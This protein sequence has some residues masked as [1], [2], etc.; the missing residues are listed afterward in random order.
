MLVLGTIHPDCGLE[1]IS[2]R[3]IK[4]IFR[5]RATL[6][7]D[8][9][10]VRVGVI[11]NDNNHG[12]FGRFGRFGSASKESTSCMPWEPNFGCWFGVHRKFLKKNKAEWT[13]TYP[14]MNSEFKKKEPNAYLCEINHK[15]LNCLRIE[16]MWHEPQKHKKQNKQKT[17]TG[18]KNECLFRVANETQQLCTDHCRINDSRMWAACVISA[19][20]PKYDFRLAQTSALVAQAR[21]PHLCIFTCTD[22]GSTHNLSWMYTGLGAFQSTGREPLQMCWRLSPFCVLWWPRVERSGS[23]QGESPWVSSM[24][25]CLP[26]AWTNSSSDGGS[27][28]PVYHHWL[29]MFDSST[30]DLSKPRASRISRALGSPRA[31]RGKTC[32]KTSTKKTSNKIEVRRW[33]FAA[34]D[35]PKRPVRLRPQKRCKHYAWVFF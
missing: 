20:L 12:L 27:W 11:V 1:L 4:A 30:S 8:P 19:G 22:D 35:A 2:K 21:N 5:R 17:T 23:V 18:C 29:C 10:L 34:Q 28:D 7:L 15:F 24:E 9:S 16:F 33:C 31:A 25:D 13:Q 6:W 14:I 3:K 26:T 32:F